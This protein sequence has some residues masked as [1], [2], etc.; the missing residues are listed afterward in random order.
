MREIT[1]DEL[2]ADVKAK[3]AVAEESNETALMIHNVGMQVLDTALGGKVTI[4]TDY[5]ADGICSA[6]IMEKTVK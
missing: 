1:L 4:H 5:D 2:I 3:E 6:Y